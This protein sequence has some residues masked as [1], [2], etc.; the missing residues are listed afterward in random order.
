MIIK[1]DVI[2]RLSL[3][4][5]I[6]QQITLQFTLQFIVLLPI[7]VSFGYSEHLQWVPNSIVFDKQPIVLHK[8]NI[9]K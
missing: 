5:V 7:H 9:I 2:I 6:K 1:Y 8:I 4:C 3:P